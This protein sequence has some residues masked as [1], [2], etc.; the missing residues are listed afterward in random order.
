MFQIIV[1]I[2]VGHH[3]IHLDPKKATGENTFFN[4]L[5]AKI[6]KKDFKGDLLC[7]IC[8]LHIFVL[9][10]GSHLVLKTSQVLKKHPAIFWQN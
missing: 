10:I 9:S 1:Q 5:Y 7:K 3:S 2:T 8:I 6:A 4:V